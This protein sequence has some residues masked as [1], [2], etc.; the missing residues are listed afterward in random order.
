M[1]LTGDFQ[2]T[3]SIDSELIPLNSILQT[4]LPQ[5]GSDIHGSTQLR[6]TLSGP[7]KNPAQLEAHLDVSSFEVGY[8]SLQFALAAPA[9]LDYRQGVFA[10][11]RTELKGS[12]TDVVLEGSAPLQA[13]GDV[14]ASANG[15]IDLQ[16]LQLLNREWQTSGRLDVRIGAQGNRT[17]PQIN[18]TATVQNASISMGADVPTL[19]KIN[20]ELDITSERVQVKTLSG[21]MGGGD[22]EVGGFA[23]YRP[24]VQ[25]NLMAKA[26]RVRV[27]YPDGIRTVLTGNLNLIGRP[28]SSNLSGQVTVDRLSLTQS[29]DLASFGSNLDAPSA[30]S[31]GM[32]QNV[33]LNVAVSSSQELQLASSQLSVEGTADL[34]VQ[35]TLAEPVVIG[36]TNLTGGEVFFNGRRFQIQNATIEFANPVRTEP[37]INLTATTTVNQFNL[38]INLVGPFDRLRATYTSDP[39]LPPVD[40][41][42]LLIT[43]QT[44]E[45]AQTSSATPMSVLAGQLGSQAGGRLQKLTG[46]SSLTIDPQIGGN[47]GNAASQLAIQERVTKNL[48]FTFA[49]DVT[50]TQGQVVQ[51]EYQV[52]RKYSVS[53][54]RDQTGGYEIQIKGHKNF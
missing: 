9:H 24:D 17:N 36:R 37:V 34:R 29:F 25:F 18:G 10:L 44:T 2:T 40:V 15:T 35:G 6:G 22:F 1:N 3:A 20:A 38:S 5:A 28:R 11:Q 32:A 39:P 16:L 43:G 54:I 33:K 49:T 41:I 27:L 13:P 26:R 8:L 42:N 47:Q 52:T 46:I 21:A 48:F 14:R 53:A 30:P 31:T 4:L 7:L 12:G 19:E 23:T 51:V 45:A 50:T